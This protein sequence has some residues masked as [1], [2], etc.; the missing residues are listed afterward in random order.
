MAP[1]VSFIPLFLVFEE[2]G[3][4]EEDVRGEESRRGGKRRCRRWDHAATAAFP[5]RG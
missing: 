3:D 5:A 4:E 1:P 2:K